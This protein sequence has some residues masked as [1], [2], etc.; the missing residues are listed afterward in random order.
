MGLPTFWSDPV[1][2][3]RVLSMMTMRSL[4]PSV[5]PS[6]KI[7]ASSFS[8]LFAYPIDARATNLANSRSSTISISAPHPPPVIVL[9]GRT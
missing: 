6:Q 1:R 5:P 4:P 3:K 2:G 8:A 7:F 9:H